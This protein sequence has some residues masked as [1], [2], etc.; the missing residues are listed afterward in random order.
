MQNSARK[1]VFK[2]QGMELINFKIFNKIRPTQKKHQHEKGMKAFKIK[3][4]K[5]MRTEVQESN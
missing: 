5:R 1:K 2:K 3:S 4:K